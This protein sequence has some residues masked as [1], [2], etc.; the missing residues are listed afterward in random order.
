LLGYAGGPGWSSGVGCLS[1]AHGPERQKLTPGRPT[2][3]AG[4]AKLTAA[5]AANDNATMKTMATNA[6]FLLF[7]DAHIFDTSNKFSIFQNDS[8]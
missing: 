6:V 8:N 2:A 5:T 1:C 4:V 7:I 3:D